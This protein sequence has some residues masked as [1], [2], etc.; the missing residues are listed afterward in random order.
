MLAPVALLVAYE[1][2]WALFRRV[3][4]AVAVVCGAVA[5][6]ALAPSYGG[7]YTALGLPATA[8]RQLL[9]AA[10]ALALAYVERPG[11]GLLAS[12]AAAGLVLAAVHPTYAIFLWLPFGGF[13]VVRALVERREARQIGIALAALVVPAAAY[14]VWLL[15]VVRD[16]RSHAPGG[17]ELQR[18]FRQY[19]GQLDVF[20]DT[21]YRPRRRC[22]AGPAPSPWPRSSSSRS[23]GSLCAAA[24]AYVLG[25]FLALAAVMLVPTLFVLFSDLVS[26]SQARRAAGF[27]PL[28]FASREASSC[29]ARSCARLVLPAALAGGSRS[30][31]C[32]RASSRTGSRT[33][34]PRS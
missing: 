11:R 21:S 30:S 14:L 23:P 22:S 28:A 34:A 9:P 5:V 15:P 10:L 17:D 18:A 25:G 24:A 27:W 12:V 19:A 7:A 31:S 4:P 2:G 32:T 1:A 26:I 6:T 20:S 29:S 33:A 8:S 13:L 16:T 3:G